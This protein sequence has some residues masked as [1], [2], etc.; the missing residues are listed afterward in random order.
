MKLLLMGKMVLLNDVCR[1][2]LW[3]AVERYIALSPEQR[4]KMSRKSEFLSRQNYD[5]QDI[6]NIY[7]KFISC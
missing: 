1:A 2:G 5:E 4:N 7:L 6:I 3:D